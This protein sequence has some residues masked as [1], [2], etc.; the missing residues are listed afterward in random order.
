MFENGQMNVDVFVGKSVYLPCNSTENTFWRVN[1]AKHE[2]NGTIIGGDNVNIQNRVKLVNGH[3]LL[4][5]VQLDYHGIYECVERVNGSE[6]VVSEYYVNPVVCG[7]KNITSFCKDG[8]PCITTTSRKTKFMY[9]YCPCHSQEQPLK[10]I[11]GYDVNFKFNLFEFIHHPDNLK[12][13]PLIS[14]LF[15]LPITSI[16]FSCC[17]TFIDCCVC[18]V[19]KEEDEK[20]PLQHHN[21]IH[22]VISRDMV[23]LFP[24]AYRHNLDTTKLEEPDD[25]KEFIERVAKLITNNANGE[26]SSSKTDQ[27]TSSRALGPSSENP[28]PQSNA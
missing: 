1:A 21:H 8:A 26:A 9:S 28:A 27:G 2:L 5:M 22:P 20:I 15:L 6:V 16:M 10:K 12:Y 7:T 23:D 25:V 13:L 11:A 14:S 3:L 19:T 24:A 17:T 4:R 18:D